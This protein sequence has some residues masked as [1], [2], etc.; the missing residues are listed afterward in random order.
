MQ[1]S[2]KKA[3]ALIICFVVLTVG[4]TYVIVK[5]QSPSTEFYL[6]GGIYPGAPR[7][8]IWCEGS[9]YF[10]KNQYGQIM[11]SGSNASQ[12]LQ[13]TINDVDTAGDYQHPYNNTGE[14]AKISIISPLII[15]S[16][17]T[18]NDVIILDLGWQRITLNAGF[19]LPS[20]TSSI[21]IQNGGFLAGQSGVT[22]FLLNATQN[23]IMDNLHFKGT[24]TINFDYAI[25]II[26]NSDASSNFIRLANIYISNATTGIY[27]G[28]D[29]TSGYTTE[30]QMDNIQISDT[31]TALKFDYAQSVSARQLTLA[32]STYGVVIAGCDSIYLENTDLE[33]NSDSH[34]FFTDSLI[35]P[36]ATTNRI[37]IL[38]GLFGQ[39]NTA[40]SMKV[41]ASASYNV[42]DITLEHC[43]FWV[44]GQ[45]PIENNSRLNNLELRGVYFVDGYPTL[46][47]VS[48]KYLGRGFTNVGQ[49]DSVA[50][51][52]WQA[53]GLLGSPTYVNVGI[54]QA[55]HVDV[56]VDSWNSSHFRI[57]VA[58][59]TPNVWW[60]AEYQ[61]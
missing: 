17:I 49:L 48:H 41:N 12:I 45:T 56:W 37:E 27:I 5:A 36:S 33:R 4:I 24:S 29:A 54:R 14:I 20:G 16:E 18:I 58:S 40:I 23:I 25:N 61:P 26:S 39:P 55:S 46:S 10:A 21:K 43:S 8:T 34:V 44:T 1:I 6:S 60:F 31:T 32:D 11:Y 30:I 51:Q 9:D 53:H 3:A 59:G 42:I 28:G 57:A 15:N 35:V 47:L 2:L 22:A 38:M 7:F 50:D 19:N 13:N 52:T